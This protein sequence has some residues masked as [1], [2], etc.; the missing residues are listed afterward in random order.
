MKFALTVEGCINVLLVALLGFV[1]LLLVLCN[2]PIRLAGNLPFGE[3]NLLLKSFEL[4]LLILL[5]H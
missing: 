3:L 1:K 2:K 4:F 5:L